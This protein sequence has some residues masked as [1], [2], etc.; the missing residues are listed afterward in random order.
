M[1]GVISNNMIRIRVPFLGAIAFCS[2]FDGT[3]FVK[4]LSLNIINMIALYQTI[5]GSWF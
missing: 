4:N 1:N 3:R 5:V 2:D